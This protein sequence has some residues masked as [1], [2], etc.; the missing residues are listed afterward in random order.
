MSLKLIINGATE[1]L[2]HSLKKERGNFP[3]ALRAPLPLS[4]ANRASQRCAGPLRNSAPRYLHPLPL[5]HDEEG[6][7]HSQW[8]GCTQG[9]LHCGKYHAS[10]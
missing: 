4:I 2:V 1:S 9:C 5:P 8:G 10:G 6:G 3:E 7:T